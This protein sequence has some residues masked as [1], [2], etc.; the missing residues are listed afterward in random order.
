[1]SLL[2]A[3]QEVAL[4]KYEDIESAHD[5]LW[6][7]A[8]AS[9]SKEPDPSGSLAATGRRRSTEIRVFSH[10]TGNPAAAS[11]LAANRDQDGLHLGWTRGAVAD[12]RELILTGSGSSEYAADCVRLPLQNRLSIPTQTVGGGMLLTHGSKAIA[13][14]RPGLMVSLGRS[15]DSPESVEAISLLLEIE[16]E[17]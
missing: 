2:S 9:C 8:V 12:L 11:E 14:L 1:M 15:G 5:Q 17:I 16:P 4:S 6:L 10:F 3:R 7:A 13:P